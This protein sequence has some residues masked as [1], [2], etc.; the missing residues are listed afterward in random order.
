[1]RQ[2]QISEDKVRH[3]F[4]TFQV[5]AHLSSERAENNR[6][7]QRSTHI[8]RPDRSNVRPCLRDKSFPSSGIELQPTTRKSVEAVVKFVKF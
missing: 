4:L 2:F 1:M 8:D 7:F 6:L 3:H 5:T